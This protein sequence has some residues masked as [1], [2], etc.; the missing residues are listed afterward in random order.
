[1]FLKG[2]KQ[3]LTK[4]TMYYILQNQGIYLVT[5]SI[6]FYKFMTHNIQVTPFLQVLI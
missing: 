2:I 1:M 3:Y 6:T 4:K 5:T